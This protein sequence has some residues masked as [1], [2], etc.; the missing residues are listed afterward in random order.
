M[1]KQMTQKQYTHFKREYQ[2]CLHQLRIRFL[3]LRQFRISFLP[4]VSSTRNNNRTSHLTKKTC[5]VP[6]DYKLG[7]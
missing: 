6:V 2:Q 3:R 1:F 5:I 4:D 7:G